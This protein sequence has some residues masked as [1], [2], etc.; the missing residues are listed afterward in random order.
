MRVFFK[1]KRVVLIVWPYR[2]TAEKDYEER[3]SYSSNTNDPGQTE[4][5]YHSENVLYGREIYTH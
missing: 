5:E 1:A 2:K 3:H 4:E